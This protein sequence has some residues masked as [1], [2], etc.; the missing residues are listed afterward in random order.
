VLVSVP[1]IYERFYAKLQEKLGQSG[2][3]KQS[4]FRA[5]QQVGWRR[6][7]RAN[8]L[9]DGATGSALIDALLWPVLDRLVAGNIRDLFGGR[10]RAAV[11]GGAAL[12]QAVGQ[13]FLG[14]GLP[15]LQ[16]YGMTETS[17]VVAA[18]S[19]DD[20]WPAT[21]GR[22]LD[23]V[24]VRLGENSE[25]QVRAPSVM[26]G[27]WN[28][29][30]DTK[31]VMTEDGWLRTGDQAVIEQGRIRISGRLK[32]IMVTSTGEKI[33]PAD[34]ELAIMA[35]PLFEQAMVVGENRPF[36]S[37]M[38]VLNRALWNQLAATLALDAQDPA[39]LQ[40][41][42]VREA[43]LARIK[44]ASKQFPYYAVPRAVW[45]TLDA[46][47]IENSLITPTLKLK[48]NALH[49]RLAPAIDGLYQRNA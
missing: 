31:A 15:L 3:F 19:L 22:A 13:C 1:R 45:A 35:D 21:V 33:P 4:L 34:L 30:D 8:G 26:Q 37:A 12:S 32:E 14:L 25:L 16:G 17:P 46:W 40:A 9:P 43:L 20:N 44:E 47:T 48:R 10:L 49:G 41:A 23:G 18:N 29:P 2:A 11:S 24:D 38:V 6:F 27:Y 28:R 5:A 42:P 36:V 39:S 7:C